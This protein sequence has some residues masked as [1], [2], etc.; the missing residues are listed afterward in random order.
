M[1]ACLANLLLFNRKSKIIYNA[2]KALY[3]QI[4]SQQVENLSITKPIIYTMRPKKRKKKKK[5]TAAAAVVNIVIT[6][7]ARA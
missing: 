4:M 1:I 3:Q 5:V 6:H 7:S 2:P